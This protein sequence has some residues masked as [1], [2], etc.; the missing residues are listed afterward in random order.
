MTGKTHKR[1]VSNQVTTRQPAHSQPQMKVF[2]RCGKGSNPRQLCPAR[3]VTC[4]RCNRQGHY[5]SQCLSRTMGEVVTSAQQT[6]LD[7][8]E[9]ND[10]YSDTIYLDAINNADEKQW[11]VTVLV[12]SNSVIFKVDT[13]AEVTA[14]LERTF[15]SFTNPVPK[16]QKSTQT[17]R[18][19]NHSP[20]EVISKVTMTLTYN[21]KS[22]NHKVF[23]IRHLQNNLLGLPAIKA[24]AVISGI[25][26][27]EQNIPDI[28]AL[29]SGLGNFKG[30]YT[31][32]L[33]PDAKP[34]SLFTP[35]NVPLLLRE[36]VKL[37]LKRIEELGVISQCKSQLLDVRAWSLYLNHLD[38]FVYVLI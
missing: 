26:A 5:C 30:E 14:L 2:K 13:G 3:D 15:Q 11:L 38:R 4:Y 28:P 1:F 27:I 17:L 12:E 9:D 31:I 6:V 20:L 16:L 24:L 34:F 8:Q 7:S 21:G 37:E 19:P 22:C 35:R 32:K 33:K 23:V 10:L 18:G 29:F 25:N 36:K